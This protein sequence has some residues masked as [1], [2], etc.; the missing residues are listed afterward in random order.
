MP[1]HIP[2][3]LLNAYLDEELN[4]RLRGEIERHLETCEACKEEYEQLR[5]L[6]AL[7]RTAPSPSFAPTEHFTAALIQTLPTRSLYLH[8]RLSSAVWIAP[9]GLLAIWLIL[10]LVFLS[11][12][13]LG[14]AKGA[15]LIQGAA[16]PSMESETNLLVALLQPLI[17]HAGTQAQ[18]VLSL[19]HGVSAAYNHLR[20]GFLAQAGVALAYWLWILSLRFGNR[21]TAQL[22]APVPYNH[23]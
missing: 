9:L 5:R 8:N 14:L 16:T 20:M 18:F 7:I 10:R 17:N 21:L 12:S 6:A 11:G 2:L 22:P 23:L 3:D 4:R 15:G 1:E 13:L 19:L